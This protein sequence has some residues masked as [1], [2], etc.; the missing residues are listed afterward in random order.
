VTPGSRTTAAE[1]AVSKA[2]SVRLP[3][4]KAWA[5]RKAPAAASRGRVGQ[6][7]RRDR[8]LPAT[9]PAS[10]TR[11]LA[12][13]AALA[14]YVMASHGG[15]LLCG[16]RKT[17][18][19][20]LSLGDGP[21]QFEPGGGGPKWRP[22]STKARTTFLATSGSRT[23]RTNSRT[24]RTK[25]MSTVGG[26]YTLTP[27]GGVS[28]TVVGGVGCVVCGVVGSAAATWVLTAGGDGLRTTGA[29]V[30]AATDAVCAVAGP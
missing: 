24:A 23:A 18:S 22:Q 2:S 26:R 13:S 10:T 15:C 9:Q 1:R 16:C 11:S 27:G 25:T 6:P 7:S 21:R 12:I 3:L 30:V 4:R 14:W 17:P 5:I 28:G 8:A 29:L 20:N 19:G